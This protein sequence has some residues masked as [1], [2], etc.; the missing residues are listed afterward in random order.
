M[1]ARR[2]EGRV[3]RQARR[4]ADITAATLANRIG[5]ARPQISKWESGK[6]FPALEKL[7]AIAEALGRD[8][9]DIFPR[10]GEP[11]LLDLRCDA[12]LTQKEASARIGT[13]HIPVINAEKG[14]RRLDP[15]YV[16]LLA[17]AYG[18]TEEELLGAQ[19]RSFGVVTAAPN[20]AS[21]PLPRTLA[22]KIDYLLA[23]TYAPADVPGDTDLTEW[24]NARVGRA[25][26]TPE[27]FTALRCGRR[28]LAEVLPEH[29]EQSAFYGALGETLGVSPLFFQPDDAVARQVMEGIRFLAA[30]GRDLALA[31]R[32]AEE[33]GVS[34]AML[35]QLTALIEQAKLEN[36]STGD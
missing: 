13:S 4:A 35:A 16:P 25:L 23:S 32:G 24:V 14:R 9:D 26:L 2:F 3:L 12:G 34:P 19:D 17:Q 15:Q 29:R 8:L 18:V 5:V 6:S 22:E 7:P 1:P 11:D 27:Q 28:T 36:P 33:L 21:T 31:A 30:G 10:S 20:I